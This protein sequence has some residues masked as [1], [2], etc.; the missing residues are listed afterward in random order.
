MKSLIL[1]LAALPL[2]ANVILTD[3]NLSNVNTWVGVPL[4]TDSPGPLGSSPQNAPL[5]HIGNWPFP[6]PYYLNITDA[7]NQDIDPTCES[8]SAFGGYDIYCGGVSGTLSWID[9]QTSLPVVQDWYDSFIF[10]CCGV[11][12]FFNPPD[13]TSPVLFRL[14]A[15][16]V[17]ATGRDN[18]IE[19]DTSYFS[20]VDPPADTA[21]PEPSVSLLV[22]AGIMGLWLRKRFTASSLHDL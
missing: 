15:R 16:L 18:L 13:L 7:A 5:F 11:K 2:S 14:D 10:Q 4:M 6:G 12:V 20:L 17:V 1:L 22:G 21:V 9:P 19:Y 3:L 8:P